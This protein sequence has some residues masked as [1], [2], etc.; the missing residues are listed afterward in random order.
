MA[1]DPQV[2]GIGIGML[3]STHG[4]PMQISICPCL[5]DQG[6]VSSIPC[7]PHGPLFPAHL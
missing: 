7:G 2:A 6:Q 4:L 3:K 1:C 5:L